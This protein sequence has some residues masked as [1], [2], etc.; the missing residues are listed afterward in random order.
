[1]REVLCFGSRVH[2]RVLHF[3]L[4]VQISSESPDVVL[5]KAMV[6][7]DHVWIGWVSVDTFS[8]D[9]VKLKDFITILPRDDRGDSNNVLGCRLSCLDSLEVVGFVHGVVVHIT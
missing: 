7:G 2:V 4:V 8:L 6:N 9:I 3:Y 5:V 1:M